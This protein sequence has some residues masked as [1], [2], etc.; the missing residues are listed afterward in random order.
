MNNLVVWRLSKALQAFIG[1]MEQN[2]GR[3]KVATRAKRAQDEARHL[4]KRQETNE[5][6]NGFHKTRTEENAWFDNTLNELSK[7]NHGH[8]LRPR[9]GLRAPQIRSNAKSGRKKETCPQP[10]IIRAQRSLPS[11]TAAPDADR[12]R[13]GQPQ[14]HAI[15]NIQTQEGIINR[16]MEAASDC[17]W[18][19]FNDEIRGDLQA[20]GTG[21]GATK[22]GREA[23]RR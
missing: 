12:A 14:S 13:R 23:R 8:Y 15:R 18:I 2:N 9:V 5:S 11:P 10:S 20:R 7:K 22:G 4:L 16:E 17:E 6:Q 19:K 21:W 1:R 3:G